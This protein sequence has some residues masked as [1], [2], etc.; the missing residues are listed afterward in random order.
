MSKGRNKQMFSFYALS[1]TI[2]DIKQ[3]A[4]SMNLTFNG[5]LLYCYKKERCEYWQRKIY[6]LHE[7]YKHEGYISDDY[8]STLAEYKNERNKYLYLGD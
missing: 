3:V 8:L 4:K 1:Q 2:S 7:I 5:Y 6:E